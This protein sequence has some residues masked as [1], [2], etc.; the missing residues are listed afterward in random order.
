MNTPRTNA[1]CEQVHEDGG[2]MDGRHKA[3]VAMCRTLEAE[4]ARLAEENALLRRSLI[5]CSLTLL[6]TRAATEA[7]ENEMVFC[8]YCG[9][10]LQAVPAVADETDEAAT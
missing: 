6:S 8:P 7:A 10:T 3:I 9:G 2:I 4:A 1:A 5:R